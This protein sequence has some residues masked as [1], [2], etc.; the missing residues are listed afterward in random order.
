MSLLPITISVYHNREFDYPRELHFLISL[1]CHFIVFFT[2]IFYQMTKW[3]N[4]EELVQTER[5]IR[6]VGG[7]WR[8]VLARLRILHDILSTPV[9]FLFVIDQFPDCMILK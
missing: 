4:V 3:N 5:F 7:L 1:L 9:T 6:P 8:A 2:F